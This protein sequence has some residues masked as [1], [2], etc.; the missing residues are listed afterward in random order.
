MQVTIDEQ[1]RL[2]L[3]DTIRRRARADSANGYWLEQ[4]EGELI[5]HP[6][7]P[8]VRKL[9]LEPTT[10]CNLHCRTCIR[11]VWED[12]AAL[13]SM[14]TF[15]RVA[16]SLDTLP[17]LKRVIFTGFGEPLSHPHILEMIEAVRK[18]DLAVT[19]GSNG[20]LLNAE[21]ARALV[22]LGIDR[23]VVSVDGVKP[24]TYADIRGATLSTVLNNIR[25]LNEMKRELGR[26]S[27]PSDSSSSRF[28]AMRPS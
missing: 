13:M 18:R 20:L 19:I 23:L 9:N 6:R 10:G 3:P 25:T 24:E 12:P 21:M 28:K 4:R 8:D 27:L 14:T 17:D 15:E 2:A 5:L 22:Q 11:N 16:A 26:F 1:G 7:R